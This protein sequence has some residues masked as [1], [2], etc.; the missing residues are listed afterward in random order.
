MQWMCVL[1]CQS[2]DEIAKRRW[3]WIEC[4][5]FRTPANICIHICN[6]YAL[7][8]ARFWYEFKINGGVLKNTAE[9]ILVTSKTISR[10]HY[11][12]HVVF[13][14]ALFLFQ[15]FV[16][17]FF[18]VSFHVFVVVLLF[19]CNLFSSFYSFACSSRL[20]TLLSK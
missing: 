14:F 4:V 10:P 15:F 1:K 13:F 11:L 5:V 8:Q 20:V 16:F 7:D 18:F 2:S 3:I 9:R 19:H 17:V 6:V 12:F